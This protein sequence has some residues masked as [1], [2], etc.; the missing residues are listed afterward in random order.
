MQ[1]YDLFKADLLPP[2]PPPKK[3]WKTEEKVP[4]LPLLQDYSFIIHPA[5]S[6]IQTHPVAYIPDFSNILTKRRVA[7]SFLHF[8]QS[9]Q[10]QQW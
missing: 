5:F 4:L 9:C 3:F 6:V 10:Q 2:P 7:S 1:T 8:L